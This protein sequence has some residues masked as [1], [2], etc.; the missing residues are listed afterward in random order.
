MPGLR[1]QE[2]DILSGQILLKAQNTS[3]FQAATDRAANLKLCLYTAP[4]S[5][6]N[7][8][9]FSSFTKVTGFG[10]ADATLTDASWTNVNEVFSYAAQTFTPVGGN[11]TGIYGYF[12]HTNAQGGG[13]TRVLACEQDPN[14]PITVNNGSDYIITPQ[15][16]FS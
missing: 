15:I 4:S 16:T 7:T 1:P 5:I 8:V 2:G 14:A 12:I 13:T 10:Y 3:T 9:T 11:W 6:T